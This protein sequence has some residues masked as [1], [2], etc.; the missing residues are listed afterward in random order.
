M[1]C[2]LA[3][4]HSSPTVPHWVMEPKMLKLF[5]A[6]TPVIWY[7]LPL[8]RVLSA[9]PPPLYILFRHSHPNAT[10]CDSHIFSGKPDGLSQ[11]DTLD[12]HLHLENLH[13]DNAV[14]IQ[15]HGNKFKV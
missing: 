11:P 15:E 3:A 12:S 13:T 8:R 9:W 2:L 7:T 10:D 4:G 14:P 6:L 1:W 5:S